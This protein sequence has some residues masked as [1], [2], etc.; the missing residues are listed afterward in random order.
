[1]VGGV[2]IGRQIACTSSVISFYKM[3]TRIRDTTGTR[4]AT[5]LGRDYNPWVPLR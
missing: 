4:F 3:V 1:M 5:D 2:D